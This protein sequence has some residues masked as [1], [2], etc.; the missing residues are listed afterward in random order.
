MPPCLTT[1]F[2]SPAASP[3]FAGEFFV[4]I[5]T[6]AIIKSKM[7]SDEFYEFEDRAYLNP[8]LSSGEQEA[9]I[10]N[11][12]NTQNQNNAQIAEQTYNLGTEVPSNLGGLGG[13]ESYFTSRYQTPQVGEM[14]E[15]LKTAAQAQALNDVMTN[16]KN[17]L[18]NRYKQAY[19]AYSKRNRGTG[20][21]GGGDDETP[22][23]TLDITT[24]TGDND[25]DKDVSIWKNAWQSIGD[26][27]F[28]DADTGK[29]YSTKAP[30][31]LM[32]ILGGGS[33]D[34]GVW[35]NGQKKTVGSTYKWGGKTYTIVKGKSGN[36]YDVVEVR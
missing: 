7:N 35:P 26:N 9:F 28:K 3:I 11:L 19:R 30:V 8:T 12:R 14:V 22:Q 4:F 23:D 6:C 17:Q 29:T 21:G 20:G 18:Q 5:G 13:G 32:G 36:P 15:T 1:F 33:S 31:S 34:M 2:Y 24:N 10:N 27:L 16:Y 25:G